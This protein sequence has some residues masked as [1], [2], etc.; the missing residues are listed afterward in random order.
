VRNLKL[1]LGYDGHEFF[2]WAI[3]PDRPTVQGALVETLRKIT[4]EKVRLYGSGRT[5]AGVHALGQVAHFKTRS[6]IPPENLQRALNALLPASI[7]VFG[8]EEVPLDFHARWHARAKTYRYRILR[9]SICSPFLRHYVYHYP[10][11]LDEAAMV[12][13]APL[14]EGEHD[15]ST[16]GSWDPEETDHNRVR[17]VYSSRFEPHGSRSVGQTF[18]SAASE[19]E[20]EIVYI[21]RGRSFLRYM[22]RK[23]VGTLLDIGKGR[24]KP[25]DIPVLFEARDRARAG[26]TVPPEGLYLV[27]VDYRQ[28]LAQPR[29]SA[30]ADADSV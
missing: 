8:V 20:E 25:E 1:T 19:S 22:V 21:V 17:T 27:E 7:R 14:F 28:A 4:G 9:A 26:P 12:R 30:Q 10:Y 18:L 5:D 6:P 13:A 3:Q 16:F 15:F 29:F 23:L 24:L 11:P 2:G